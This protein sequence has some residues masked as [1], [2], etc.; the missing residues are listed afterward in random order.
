MDYFVI[1]CDPGQAGALALLHIT[2][3]KPVLIDC[4]DMPSSPKMSGKGQQVS[5]QLLNIIAGE[6]I[7]TCRGMMPSNMTP[8]VLDAVIEQVGAMKGQGVTSCFSFGQATGILQ[9]VLAAH[10]IPITYKRP[11][12]W[13]K[14]HGIGSKKKTETKSQYKDKS[15]TIALSMFPD[16]AELFKLKKHCDRAEAVLIGLASLGL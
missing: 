10:N 5:P 7:S 9:G 16:K 8:Y 15:R 14:F 4:W 1:G 2:P 3:Q 6:I 11:Q 13:K 12:V